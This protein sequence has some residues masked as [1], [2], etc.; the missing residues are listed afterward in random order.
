MRSWRCKDFENV[1]FKIFN[2]NPNKNENINRKKKF[3]LGSEFWLLM[4][5]KFLKLTL[6]NVP[7]VV[8]FNLLTLPDSWVLKLLLEMVRCKLGSKRRLLLL[9]RGSFNLITHHVYNGRSTSLV[10]LT[11]LSLFEQHLL[12]LQFCLK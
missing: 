1:R 8:D 12:L 2:E 11:C 10:L 6:Y 4:D 9:R 3:N 5:S 7:N